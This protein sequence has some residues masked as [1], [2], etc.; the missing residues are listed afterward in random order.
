MGSTGTAA[1]STRMSEA[2][3]RTRLDLAACYRLVDEITASSLV[4]ID[5][6]GNKVEPC[7]AQVNSAGFAMP[8]AVHMAR[9]E[10]ACVLHTHSI[11]GWPYRCKETGYCR[12]TNMPCR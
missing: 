5:A 9:P 10:I 3:W 7:D 1:P 4:K 11:A 2:K 8:S 6:E 12:S